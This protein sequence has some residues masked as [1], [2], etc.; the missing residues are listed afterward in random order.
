MNGEEGSEYG[1]R[2]DGMIL[3]HVSEFKGLGCVLDELGTYDVE[4]RRK[5]ASGR[6]VASAISRLQLSVERFCIRHC[7]FLFLVW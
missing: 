6:K 4:C 3:E 5:V 2:V 1:F 7:S